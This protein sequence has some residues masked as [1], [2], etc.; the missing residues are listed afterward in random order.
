MNK[1]KLAAKLLLLA[2][3]MLWCLHVSPAD[4]RKMTREEGKDKRKELIRS[5]KLEQAL[6]NAQQRVHRVGLMNLCVTN[7][8]FIGSETRGLYESLGG[9]FN[10]S[11]D[12]EM[13]APSCEY[14]PNSGLEF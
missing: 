7:W 6:P 8:G 12:K 2:G 9:C 4:A 13:L 11:P 3:V 10:P 1:V 5:S 14:H